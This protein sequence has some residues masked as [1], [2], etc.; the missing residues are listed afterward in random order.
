MYLAGGFPRDVTMGVAPKDLDIYIRCLPDETQ[1]VILEKASQVFS[2]FGH[3][4]KLVGSNGEDR[5]DGYPMVYTVFESEDV[6]EGHLPLNLMFSPYQ[7]GINMDFDIGLC[8]M[9]SYWNGRGNYPGTYTDMFTMSE[10]ALRDLTEG[11]LTLLRW[12]NTDDSILEEPQLPLTE[13]DNNYFERRMGKLINHIERVKN[14]YPEFPLLLGESF[15]NTR[16]AGTVLEVLSERGIINDPRQVLQAEGQ[17]L[18]G[19]QLRLLDGDEVI[20]YVDGLG[21]EPETEGWRE[22][23]VRHQGRFR[24]QREAIERLHPGTFPDLQGDQNGVEAAVS[25]VPG[26]A[27]VQ[28]RPIDIIDAARRAFERGTHNFNNQLG[29]G[30]QYEPPRPRPRDSLGRFVSGTGRFRQQTFWANPRRG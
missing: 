21:G 14:K 13:V 28:P 19:D 12:E 11:T 27:P 4:F 2:A 7:R 5:E 29:I 26:A 18:E 25:G 16:H 23:E 30:E 10:Y 22:W 8:E 1:E 17:E 3:K 9:Y 6:P 15:F 24:A 20:R